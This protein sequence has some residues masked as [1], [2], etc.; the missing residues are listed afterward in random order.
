VAYAVGVDSGGTHSNLRRVGPDGDERPMREIAGSL[1]SNRSDTELQDTFGRIFSAIRALQCDG[2]VHVWITCAG[3]SASTRERFEQLLATSIDGAVTSVGMCN[4]AV[5]LMLAHDADVVN[6][7]AGTGSVVMART[8]TGQIVTLGGDEWVAADYGSAFWIGLLGIRAAYRA[9]EG[10]P[11]TGLLDSLTEQFE[12]DP[13]GD[14]RTKVRG[15]V[16]KLASMGT[17]TKP[18][19]ASFAVQVTR[20]AELGD[21]IAQTIVQSAAEE[22][23]ANAARVY[24]QLAVHAGPA[25]LNPRFVLTGSVGFRSNFYAEAFR[26]WLNQS[27]FDVRETTGEPVDLA[28]QLNGT[29]EALA[30]ARLLADGMDI[31]KIDGTAYTIL[32]G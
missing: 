10:G 32:R 3:Y 26:A 9:V 1:S 6:I 2:P 27:L 24:R 7:V 22:L 18:R 23:A 13:G 30:L 19:I 16:R 25:A 11:E 31:P 21:E 28:I 14:T 17:Q 20:Q 12:P 8:V 4:D 29:S 5:G 15:I